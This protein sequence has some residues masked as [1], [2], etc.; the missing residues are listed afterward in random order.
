[1]IVN[2][3]TNLRI[4]EHRQLR[5]SPG[6]SEH[7]KKKLGTFCWG[8]VQETEGIANP[9]H[10]RQPLPSLALINKQS[11][12]TTSTTPDLQPHLVKAA[13]PLPQFHKPTI[14][15]LQLPI[16]EV[17]HGHDVV[18]KASPTKLCN[19]F[20]GDL[21]FHSASLTPRLPSRI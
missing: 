17:L 1:M 20:C 13:S 6:R 9:K 8:G 5:Q 18:G 4:A 10:W 7:M 15:H 2:H 12:T 14:L 16:P 11:M 19:P 3:W 21:Q